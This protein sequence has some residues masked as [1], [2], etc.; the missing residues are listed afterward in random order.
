MQISSSKSTIKK[1][2]IKNIIKKQVQG[3]PT[4]KEELEQDLHISQG[5]GVIRIGP[6]VKLPHRLWTGFKESD[7]SGGFSDFAEVH[8]ITLW[9]QVNLMIESL[10]AYSRV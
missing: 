4:G 2:G 7:K 5:Y 3:G 1:K 10:R 6:Q 9:W 8:Y